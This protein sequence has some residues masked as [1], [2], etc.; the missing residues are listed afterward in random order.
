MLFNTQS[1]LV[2][3]RN[4]SKD[5]VGIDKTFRVFFQLQKFDL[6]RFSFLDRNLGKLI[7][8]CINVLKYSNYN[9]KREIST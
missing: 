3:M 4:G 6:D 7:L 2:F 9:G 5:V 1:L 8:N